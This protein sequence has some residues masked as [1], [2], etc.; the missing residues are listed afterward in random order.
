MGKRK[1][2]KD[3]SRSNSEGAN[4][5]DLGILKPSQVELILCLFSLF[6]DQGELG[7]AVEIRPHWRIVPLD[8]ACPSDRA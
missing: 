3:T 5:K 7:D 6:V 2:R 1:T 8:P 4:A